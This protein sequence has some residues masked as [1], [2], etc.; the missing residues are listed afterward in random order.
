MQSRAF[1]NMTKP[2]NLRGFLLS[3]LSILHFLNIIS[4]LSSVNRVPEHRNLFQY[5]SDSKNKIFFSKVKGKLSNFQFVPTR[6]Q[7]LNDLFIETK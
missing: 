2:A 4:N 5:T 6:I 7:T 3:Q 1:I